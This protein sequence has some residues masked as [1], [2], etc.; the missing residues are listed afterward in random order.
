MDQKDVD[1]L[2]SWLSSLETEIQESKVYKGLLA[3]LF[4]KDWNTHA[5]K[6]DSQGTSFPSQL[7]KEVK[8]GG[9][10]MIEMCGELGGRKGI[11]VCSLKKNLAISRSDAE[12]F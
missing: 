12:V 3:I 4:A 1:W 11:Y 10:S 6:V 7:D 5:V 8:E 9:M 2:S